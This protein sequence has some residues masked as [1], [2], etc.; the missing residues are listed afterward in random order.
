MI[1]LNSAEHDELLAC[2]ILLVWLCFFV[3]IKRYQIPKG[4]FMPVRNICQ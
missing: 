2:G 3:V 4:F 1:Q